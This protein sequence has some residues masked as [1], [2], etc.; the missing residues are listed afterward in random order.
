MNAPPVLALQSAW[1]ACG[2]PGS[3]RFPGCLSEP[4]G[5]AGAAVSA[6]VQMIISSLRGDRAA[7]GRGQE[8][9][10]HRGHRGRHAQ[11][12]A[13]PRLRARRSFGPQEEGGSLGPR[14]P[15]AGLGQ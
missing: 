6:R 3:C 8:R 14:P 4:E 12:A 9:A 1:E 13:A 10:L 11:P 5:A 15:G 7:R 2:P